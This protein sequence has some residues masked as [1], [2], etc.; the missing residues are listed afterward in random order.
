MNI[1][2]YERTQFKV[3]ENTKYKEVDSTHSVQSSLQSQPL[4]VTLYQAF[5][6]QFK[7]AHLAYQ[8]QAFKINEIPLEI[9]ALSYL[10]VKSNRTDI[11]DKVYSL[12]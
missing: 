5:I 2:F 1:D 12:K 3:A 9:S 6:L 8:D 7:S 11:A 4:W 10:K